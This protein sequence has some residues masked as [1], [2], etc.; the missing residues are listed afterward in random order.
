[1]FG[2]HEIPLP[3]PSLAYTAPFAR[4]SSQAQQPYEVP[5]HLGH[6]PSACR[7]QDEGADTLGQHLACNRH[8][9]RHCLAEVLLVAL[10]RFFERGQSGRFQRK[11]P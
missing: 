6:K 1:M 4:P 5:A 9:G 7:P 2:E 3:A 11:R 10:D 8:I